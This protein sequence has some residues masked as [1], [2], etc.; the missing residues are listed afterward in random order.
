[1]DTEIALGDVYYCI[2][3]TNPPL[4][5]IFIFSGSEVMELIDQGLSGL[6]L[7]VNIVPLISP[8]LTGE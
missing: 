3:I 7:S 4:G 1:M 8:L 5:C 6:P 2:F